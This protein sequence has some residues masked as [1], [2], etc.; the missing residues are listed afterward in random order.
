M[1]YVIYYTALENNT[2]VPSYSIAF[3]KEDIPYIIQNAKDEY[4]ACNFLVFKLGEEVTKEF[5]DLDKVPEEMIWDWFKNFEKELPNP[6]RLF[7]VK[8][9]IIYKKD[10]W[11]SCRFDIKEPIPSY[12]KFDE[13]PETQR[14]LLFSTSKFKK[15]YKDI[16]FFR[17]D[18]PLCNDYVKSYNEIVL[19]N[20]PINS[21]IEFLD[22]SDWELNIRNFKDLNELTIKY[23][24]NGTGVVHINQWLKTKDI[25]PYKKIVQDFY[26]RTPSLIKVNAY[27]SGAESK[28]ISFYIQDGKINIC[29]YKPLVYK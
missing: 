3:T 10:S 7:V 27:F 13:S 21:T 19:M 6:E 26:D 4:L 24:G 12:I 9:N 17:I 2:Y 28:D 18:G 15:E 11:S 25:K 8:D 16:P 29:K 5:V 23:S 22:R 14:S 1:K 20:S